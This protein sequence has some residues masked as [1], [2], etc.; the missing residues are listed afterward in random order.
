[1]SRAT[2]ERVEIARYAFGPLLEHD[3]S[4]PLPAHVV[5]YRV[6]REPPIVPVMCG[7]L[8]CRDWCWGEVCE[9][10]GATV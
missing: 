5:K 9:R 7:N 1:M 2:R 4:A 10:C 8:Y 6:V 3:P